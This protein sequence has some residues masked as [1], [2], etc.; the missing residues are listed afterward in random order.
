[1]KKSKYESR[2][3]IMIDLQLG[4]LII[5]QVLQYGLTCT[6]GVSYFLYSPTD[7]IQKAEEFSFVAELQ[8]LLLLLG[9]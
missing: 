6:Q 5:I 7:S 1:M 8:L 3:F 2:S 9:H 4:A